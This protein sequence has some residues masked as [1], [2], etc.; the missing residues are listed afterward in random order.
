MN[1]GAQIISDKSSSYVRR[2]RT[3]HIEEIGFEN[4]CLILETVL[5]IVQNNL[6]ING[7]EYM[8]FSISLLI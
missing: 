4:Y 5:S 6:N 7:D 8:L 2:H 1:K 3:S